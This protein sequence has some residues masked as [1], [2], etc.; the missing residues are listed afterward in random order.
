MAVSVVKNSL[1]SLLFRSSDKYLIAGNLLKIRANC[2]FSMFE[3]PD[4]FRLTIFGQAL[5]KATMSSTMKL[6]EESV[7]AK[8]RRLGSVF[9]PVKALCQ[10]K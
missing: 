9:S 3:T 10:A 1:V 2:S 5:A 6:Y 4:K 8:F 7:S